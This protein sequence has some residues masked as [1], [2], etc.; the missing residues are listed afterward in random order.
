MKGSFYPKLALDGIRK[1]KRLYFPYILAGS[2]MVMIHYILSFLS[3]SPALAQMEGGTTLSAILPLGR[4]VI[5][6]FSLLFLFY[7]NSFLIKQRCREFGLFSILGMDKRNICRLMVWEVLFV[8]LAAFG[9]GIAAGIALS[10]MAELGLLNLLRMP[11]H[12]DLRIGSNALRW[13]AGI[14]GG[15]YLLLLCNSL[16]RVSHAKPLDLLQSSKAGERMPKRAWVYALSGVILLALAY[17]LAVSIQEPTD[18]LFWFFVA[19]LLVI[20]A[21][22]LLFVSGSVVFCKL[23]QADKK[24][25]YKP[26]HFVSV[27]SMVY[28]MK[29]NGAGLAS[30]CVLLTMVLVMISSTSCLY[31]GAEDAVINR[32]PNNINLRTV[33]DRREYIGEENLEDLRATVRIYSGEYA[34]LTG[35]RACEM[36][37]VI[38]EK[39]IL[40]NWKAAD[41]YDYSAYKGGYLHVIPL[42]DYNL[43]M[44]QSET[45]T[46]EECLLYS[47]SMEYPG[48]TFS[49]QNGKM[50]RVKARLSEFR[51]D[52]ELQGMTTPVVY[53]VVADLDAFAEPL[54]E[55]QNSTGDPVL[56]FSWRCGFDMTDPAAEKAVETALMEALWEKNEGFDDTGFSCSVTSRESSREDFYDVYGSLFFLG[57]VLSAVFLLAAVLIIYYKQICEGY[58]D[59]ARFD[60]MQKVGMTKREIRKSINSQMLTVFFLPLLMA[61]V[62]LAFAFP[63]ITKILL[64]FTFSNTA[65]SI[66]VNAVCFALFGLL[67]ALVYKLTS[68][69]YY[70]IVCTKEQ[71]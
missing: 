37:G 17:Y 13:T 50:Y 21:T 25:Y 57:L 48:D 67:Y 51:V 60:I 62:H 16:I 29:R 42:S 34:E 54:L 4:L 9:I 22:Y 14:Y 59:S 33:F 53:M 6:V 20:I 65:L 63:F 52:G 69:A 38:T 15:I 2:L 28:R 39:G 64:M 66:T 35:V 3:E 55:L 7:T 40:F 23:L 41:L 71:G 43:L 47:G 11:I 5:A 19:V 31:F 61:G 36:E 10:K 44:D 30:I 27:S 12:Y 45:L 24:Y 46:H 32:C 56:S 8:A 58:E 26:N 68:G 1:N 70:A 49:V 18:A